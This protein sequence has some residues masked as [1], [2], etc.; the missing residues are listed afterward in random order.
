MEIFR[1]G[2]KSYP[3]L[4][5]M[6]NTMHSEKVKYLFLQTIRSKFK[7]SFVSCLQHYQILTNL[8][9]LSNLETDVGSI[10][11]KVLQTNISEDCWKTPQ[12]QS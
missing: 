9:L 4:C 3:Y 11:H 5:K 1:E 2:F 6:L 7:F 10:S 8:L 12:E